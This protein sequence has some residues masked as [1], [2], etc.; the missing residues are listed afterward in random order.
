MMSSKH[1]ESLKQNKHIEK[2]CASRW[3][4]T[5]NHYMMYGQQNIKFW[6]T[7][8]KTDSEIR[9]VSRLVDT[10]FNYTIW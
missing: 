3:S 10:N 9:N 2:K 4:F 6:Q 1:V 7:Q 5:K 8:V